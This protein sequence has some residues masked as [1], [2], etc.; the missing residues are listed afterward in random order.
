ML[1]RGNGIPIASLLEAQEVIRGRYKRNISWW[2]VARVRVQPA[3]QVVEG[4]V[5][6][7]QDDDMLNLVHRPR[8]AE[9]VV[10]VAAARVFVERHL[11][12]EHRLGQV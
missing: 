11:R 3:E 8:F 1:V 10:D 7:H 4:P 6:E 9:M 5:L 2:A 12:R